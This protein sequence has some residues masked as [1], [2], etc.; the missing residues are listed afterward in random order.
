[1]VPGVFHVL[2][3]AGRPLPLFRHCRAQLLHGARD[4]ETGGMGEFFPKLLIY[5]LTWKNKFKS[6]LLTCLCY[7]CTLAQMASELRKQDLSIVWVVCFETKTEKIKKRN[8]TCHFAIV[9]I[10]VP[11]DIKLFVE[12]LTTAYR[13]YTHTHIQLV[14]HFGQ[15]SNRRLRDSVCVWYLEQLEQCNTTTMRR[16]FSR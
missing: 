13:I 7:P 14:A 9:C 15:A 10:R 2:W 6:T 5:F 12:L 1:M 3:R 11:E 16:I 8:I 4:D